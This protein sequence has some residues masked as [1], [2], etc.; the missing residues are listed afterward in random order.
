MALKD[1]FQILLLLLIVTT[2]PS[3]V[4]FRLKVD[5][6]DLK[7]YLERSEVFS[8][9]FTGFSLYDPVR[10]KYIFKYNDDRF[11]T[12]ASNTK[13]FTFYAGKKILGDSIPGINYVV[14]N[15]TLFF[16]GTGDPTFLDEDFSGQPVYD[17]L[18][19]SSCI[20][21]Y[22]EKELSDGRFGPGWAWDDYMYYFSPEKSVM[23]IYSNVIRL[24][25]LP[26][27]PSLSVCPA[28]FNRSI[29]HFRDSVFR[30]SRI[31]NDNVFM[32]YHAQYPDTVDRKIPFRYSTPLMLRLLTD[33]LRRP[34]HHVV[35]DHHSMISTLYSQH[36]DSLMKKMMLESD[37]FIAEQILLMCAVTLFDTLNAGLCI[38]YAEDNIL[39]EIK[40]GMDWVD[41]SGLSRYNKFTPQAIVSLLYK[42]YEEYP[43]ETIMELFPKG[44]V[45]GTLKHNFRNE[46]PY[47][48]A[49]T[50]SLK[51]VYNLSGFL[52]TRT[53]RWLI[54]SFMN[55]NFEVSSS[56]VKSEMEKVLKNIYE[57]F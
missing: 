37:N 31:E 50:G 40:D 7:K 2:F 46:V 36:T 32:V 24:N 20:L 44:G 55:N 57:K 5:H 9:S 6:Q 4:S 56:L 8:N 12:P 17:F 16:T 35:Q 11:F 43:R 1:R 27:Q 14:K 49:K 10:E 3:C 19:T 33:T 21:A 42:I 39:T 13:L 22:C 25:H 15:D 38:S 54:F 47:V 48:V 34:V 41:G 45:S 18:A 30:T 23:P 26:G 28:Y 53:G 29:I 51:H 52:I